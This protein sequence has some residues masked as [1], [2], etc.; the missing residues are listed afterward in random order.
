MNI[1]VT[2]LSIGENYT[3]HYTLRMAEDILKFS[4]LN[5]Y[6]TTDCRYIIDEMYPDNP[7]IHINEV[8]RENIKIRL[9]ICDAND[10][11]SYSDDFNFNLRYLCLEP[12]K[13]LDETV[14]IFTDCDNSFDEWNQEKVTKFIDEYYYK[15]GYDFFGPRTSFLW[16]SFLSQYEKTPNREEGIFWHKIY[17]YDLD[18]NPKPEWNE[19]PL[20]AE[21]LLIFVNN[22][23][24]L[25]KMYEQWKT[26]HDYLVNKE[27]TYGTWAEGFEIGVSSLVSGFKPYDIGWGH[28]I[29]SKI[30][31]ANGYKTGK[32]KGLYFPTER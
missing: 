21:Y 7:R 17:N 2:T 32:R 9:P 24:K 13:D 27:C 6:I 31:V 10:K 18:K 15:L 22:N 26:F 20:P 28:E 29:W 1:V 30:F 8:K 5:F 4:D 23:G 19:S 14:V 16:K 3:K 11:P 25:N 12:V